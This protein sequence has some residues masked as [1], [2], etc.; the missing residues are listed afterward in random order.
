[1][2]RLVGLA[3]LLAAPAWAADPPCAAPSDQPCTCALD[4]LRPLQG[5]LG[6][7]QV[8]Y[9]AAR[10]KEQPDKAWAALRADPIK[11]VAGPG[12]ALFITDHHHGADA[13]RLAGYTT[14][15]CQVAARPAFATVD[16]FWAGLQADHLVRLADA[17]GT[18]I[19]P[20][21]LPPNL[22]SLPDDPYRTLAGHLRRAGGFCRSAMQLEFAEFTWADWL[23]TRPE[24]PIAAVRT[25]S[26]SLVPVAL[27]LS[28]SAAAKDVPGYAGDL[29]PGARCPGDK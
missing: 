9:G 3:L 22:A 11:V 19:T 25:A 8:R 1:M 13:W 5:A 23:R 10:I 24:L 17:E 7:E 12:G 27:A 26:T 29:P 28:R 6:L 4:A 14:G 20:D 15:L 16:A 2:I 18:P 21:Q